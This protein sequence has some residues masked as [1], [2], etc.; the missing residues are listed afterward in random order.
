MKRYLTV[1][2]AGMLTLAAYADKKAEA[3]GDSI[4]DQLIEYYLQGKE[5]LL[6]KEKDA[7]LALFRKSGQWENFYFLSSACSMVKVT[8]DGQMLTGLREC[9]KL[10]EFA[11]DHKHEYGRGI[12]LA[13]LG[14]IYEYMGDYDEALKQMREAYKLLRLY[15]L[16]RDAISLICFYAYTLEHVGNYKEEAA[17]LEALQSLYKHFEWGDTSPYIYGSYQDGLFNIKTLLEIRQKKLKLAGKHVSQLQATIANGT[18]HDEFEALRVITEY[19]KAC[20]DYALALAATDRME[21][22]AKNAANQWELSLLRSDL[23]RQLDRS[24]EAYD[25]LRPMINQH[26][27]YRLNQLRQQVSEVD[28][29]TELDELRIHKQEMRFWFTVG[30]AL[31]I[32]IALF[33]YGIIRYHAERKLRKANAQL[34]DAYDQLEETTTAKERIESDLRIARDIQKS[35]V[36]SSFPTCDGLDVYGSMMPAREVG[37]DLF[38]VLLIEQ[39]KLY[40]C[41]GDVSGK[42][43]PASLFMAQAIRL[44]RALA[45][46]KISPAEIA[47]YMNRELSDG[48]ESGMFVTMFI[49]KIALDTGCLSFCNCGHNPPVLGCGGDEAHFMEMKTNVPIGLWGGIKYEGETIDSIKNKVLFIY[50]DG[51]NEAENTHQEQFGDEHL[52]DILRK[53]PYSTSQKLIELLGKKVETH[54]NGAE[55]NDDLTMLCLKVN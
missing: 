17:V 8:N 37:G 9:R 47:G 27:I 45:K 10:Y 54:R 19:Y 22:L 50:T 14:A 6:F 44:F 4:Y 3:I 1:I 23:L 24:D 30:I 15:P 29:M 5:D 55:P 36:P 18:Q 35:M 46:L 11:R 33:I 38:D 16:K 48:N 43:V 13:Q 20:G 32:I 2:L 25:Q 21:P 53:T 12:V 28:T 49:G 42:G 52:L 34:Q 40:F 41:V 26:N 31:T 39:S 7:A 51:L